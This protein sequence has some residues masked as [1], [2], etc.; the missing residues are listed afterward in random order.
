[1]FLYISRRLLYAIFVLF[2]V[3]TVVFFIA[4]ITGDPVSIMLPPDA[5]LEQENQLRSSLG[6]DKPLIQQ[7][8]IFMGNLLQLDLGTSLRYGE[9]T[10]SLISER[11]PAT[12]Q[13][14][15]AAMVFSLS[16]AVPAGIITAIKRGKW[17]EKL[18]M[19]TVIFLQSVPV[20]WVGILLVLI[21]SVTLG[22]LPTGGVGTAW[23]L[24]LPAI[25]LGTHLLALV[26]RL[27][28]ASLVESLE[29]DYIRTAKA[30]GLLPKKVVGKHAM[31]N[32]LLPVVTI[33]GLEVG[34]LLG[35]SVV[36]ETVFAWPGV[37]QLLILAIYNR[38]FPL[39]QAIIIILAGI[40]VVVN[41]LV[42][43]LYAVIDPRIK[44][45]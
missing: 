6:L 17:L 14:G 40:F 12:I 2:G 20:F 18:V 45:S 13:L 39:V 37:G 43:I 1:M 25:A 42:D 30:K 4:R 33:V 15:V 9:S 19:S 22:W 34:A 26:A 24:I 11:M 35:G 7:Y 38:D 27:L 3:A 29:S 32:S 23:H 31:R 16:I 5:T 44:Y 28:R 8:V 21:F 36:T 41:L 10:L